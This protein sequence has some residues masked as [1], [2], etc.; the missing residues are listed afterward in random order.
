M[1]IKTMIVSGLVAPL[2]A[3]PVGARGILHDG[4]WDFLFDNHIDTHLE[5][6][7]QPNG[8]LIGRFYIIYTGEIDPV[9]GLPVARHPRGAGASEECGVDPIKCV[10]GWRVYAVPGSAK[11]LYHSGV[12]GN[13]HPVWLVNRSDI[14]IPGVYTHFHWIGFMSTDAR[15]PDVPAYCDKENASG[16]E[17]MAPMAVNETCDGWF[18]QLRATRAFAFEHGGEVTPVYPGLDSNTHTNIVSN[19]ADVPGITPTRGGGGH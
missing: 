7:M 8:S 3:G 9:T 4:P 14:P 19:Y 18:M 10:L 15:A 5:T 2:L 11:F 12:N 16:L 13:D 1:N 6:K 17:D